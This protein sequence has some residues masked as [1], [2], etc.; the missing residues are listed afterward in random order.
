MPPQIFYLSVTTFIN[1]PGRSF[2]GDNLSY[3]GILYNFTFKLPLRYIR[4]NK[5]IF[6]CDG[7]WLNQEIG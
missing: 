6:F 5:N 7:G 2:V 1:S 4:L 3:V